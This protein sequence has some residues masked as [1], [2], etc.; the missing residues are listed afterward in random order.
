M[1]E[2]NDSDWIE[3]TEGKQF[4]R[5]LYT[6]P[7]CFLCTSS[8]STEC[9]SVDNGDANDEQ[10]PPTTTTTLPATTSNATQDPSKSN[11]SAAS[12]NVMVLSW[13]T[14]TNNN[15]R[16]IFSLNRRRHSSNL[17]K[18]SLSSSLS[19]SSQFTLSVPVQG[20]EE[21]VRSV[22]SVSG[23]FGS[24]FPADYDVGSASSPS[25][26]APG[27]PMSKRQRKKAPRFPTGIPHLERVS[28]GDPD[29]HQTANSGMDSNNH[30]NDSSHANSHSHSCFAIQ[31]T[32]AQLVCRVYRVMSSSP[33]S[34]SLDPTN[35]ALPST[36]TDNSDT[37]IID[38]DHDLFL[39]EVIRARVRPDYFDVTH[40]LFRPA[41][42]D[43]L[44]YLTFFGSQTFGYV[45]SSSSSSSSSPVK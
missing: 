18:S 15:G 3:L 1:T 2:T 24:K 10:S 40:N 39:A 31:G 8:S 41:T 42:A 23:R 33:L 29:H 36:E 28:M 7:V 35:E 22:G 13:L 20:M 17:L 14:A 26:C 38:D 30:G 43:T 44:P 16:F 34:V 25:T 45:V 5:L 19:V 4:S 6:N 12:Q 11:R 21:L 32:V 9:G 27:P 37:S